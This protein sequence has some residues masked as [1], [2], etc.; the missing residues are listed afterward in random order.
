MKERIFTLIGKILLPLDGSEAAYKAFIPAKSLA[1]LLD[2]T[3]CILHVSKEERTQQELLQRLNIK[4]SDMGC[5]VVS[6]KGGEPRDVIIEEAERS[7]YI[8]MGTHGETCDETLRMGSTTAE[9]IEGTNKPVLLIKPNA[10]LNITEGKW[11]PHKALIPLN[12]APGSA[13]ALAPAM[14]IL[15]KTT[16]KIDLLHIFHEKTEPISEEGS[17]TAPYYEDYPQHEWP[18]WSKEFLKR[19][20]P[21]MKNHIKM[22]VSIS[23]GDP[24]EEI[25]GFAE[26]N[27]NDFIAIAWHGTLSK[28]RAMT[29]KKI[30]FNSNC[31][32]M[33]I[34]IQ[35]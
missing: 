26:K 25:A 28:F 4:P 17:F 16:A 1:E 5:F 11:I 12:G 31:P 20:C 10:C 13:Q 14:R 35:D 22:N 30:L 8:I 9:V 29:L 27:Q 2:L 23:K 33:L 32:I 7:S 19:F 21:T 18:S 15:E 24:A 6:Q 3:L 34:R